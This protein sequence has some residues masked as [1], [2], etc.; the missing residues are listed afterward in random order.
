ML[1][2]ALGLCK[3]H[4]ASLLVQRVDRLTRDLET[5]AKIAK[6]PSVTVWVES[7]PNADNLQINQL[8]CQ[9]VQ[10]LEFIST[11]TKAA[12]AATKERGA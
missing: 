9:V 12:L 4:G 10:E 3:K 11:R 8:G 7:L 2:K 6:D 1:D 5:L